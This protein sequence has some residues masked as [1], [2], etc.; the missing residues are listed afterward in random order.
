MVWRL[1]FVITVVVTLSGCDTVHK[2]SEDAFRRQN[3]AMQSIMF[4]GAKTPVEQNRVEFFEDE[5]NSACRPLQEVAVV[6]FSGGK[7]G[8]FLKLRAFFASFSC[9][10]KVAEIEER[11]SIR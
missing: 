5:I 1:L 10:K 7:P 4:L 9:D 3:A 6:K 2:F 8:F 11:L